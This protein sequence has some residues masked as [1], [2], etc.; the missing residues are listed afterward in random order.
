ML[1][2]FYYTG[3]TND[4]ERRINEH[5]SRISK[6]FTSKRLPVV[7]VYSQAF[8]FIEDAIQSEKL[9]KGWSRKK[10]DALI[11]GDFAGLVQL[12]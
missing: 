10:R 7:L 1:R 8:Q 2:V 12:S 3:V 11:R 5:N 6:G 9:L 4:L